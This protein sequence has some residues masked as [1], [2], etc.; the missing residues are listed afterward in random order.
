[1]ASGGKEKFHP[2]VSGEYIKKLRLSLG[3]TQ[4]QLA[5][6]M[7]VGNVTVAN[8]EKSG[9]DGTKSSNFQNF[10]MLT[11]LLKQSIRHPDFLPRKN[12]VRYMKLAADHELMPY[13]LPHLSE[14][15]IDYL[16]IINSGSL[17]GVMFALLC[18]KHLQMKGIVAPT[19][20]ISKG[21]EGLLNI[22]NVE[23]Q[24]ILDELASESRE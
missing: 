20:D 5:E 13:Y 21:L 22:S 2:V 24:D 4:L 19:E 1:M 23:D 15:E 6:L 8:W 18:D 10:K 17:C 14:L 9:L 7:E 12:L 11:A 16:N 3:L